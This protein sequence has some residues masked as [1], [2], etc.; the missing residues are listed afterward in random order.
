MKQCLQNTHSNMSTPRDFERCFGPV[1]SNLEAIWKT[2]N[3]LRTLSR[4]TTL[5]LFRDLNRSFARLIVE[6]RPNTNET[7]I[8]R[9]V[10]HID[11]FFLCLYQDPDWRAC[12]AH[13]QKLLLWVC[14]LHDIK[15]KVYDEST[16]DPLHPFTSAAEV[17]R[18]FETWRWVEGLWS[19]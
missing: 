17:L 4:E 9:C 10:S 13:D 12:D 2:I 7:F 14:L 1:R 6:F 8:V 16:K 15:K 11:S 3:S 5:E 18:Y 19:R